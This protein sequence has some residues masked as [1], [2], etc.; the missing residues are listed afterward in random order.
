MS[1]LRQDFSPGLEIQTHPHVWVVLEHVLA[2]HPRG[3]AVEFGT[4]SGS[5]TL[6][7][8]S[9][10]PVYSFDSFQGLPEDWGGYPKGS[11]AGPPPEVPNATLI[12][13]WF[14]DTLPA[15]DFANLD[16]G[17]VHIDCDLYSS[18]KTVLKHIGPHLKT[19]CYVVFDEYIG[20]DDEP[21]A[22]GEYVAEHDI[23]FEA[24]ARSDQPWAIRIL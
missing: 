13:G 4:G 9:H 14:Q 21:R 24:V 22:F 3:V 19:G 18:T 12:V 1:D 20:H 16:I 15:F 8:A 17:L 5:S 7:I 2:L 10:M 11:F 6:L 23:E